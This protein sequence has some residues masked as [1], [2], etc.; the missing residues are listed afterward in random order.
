MIDKWEP[1]PGDP[2]TWWE[3]EHHR[4][5][6][7]PEALPVRRTGTLH[8]IWYSPNGSG[9]IVAYS[10]T[11]PSRLFGS[12]MTTVRPDLGH[13]LRHADSGPEGEGAPVSA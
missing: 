11:C 12:Y 5:L 13:V 1:A 4:S 9:E 6:S 3:D 2:V 7:H 8:S 10:V